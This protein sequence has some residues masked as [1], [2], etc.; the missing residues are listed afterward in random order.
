MRRLV[1]SLVVVL[2]LGA[3]A[4]NAAAEDEFDVS[5]KGRQVTVTTKGDWHINLDYPWKLVVEVAPNQPLTVPKS[6][7]ELQAKKATVAAKSGGSAVLK[8]AVC[9]QTR[10]QNGCRPFQKSLTLP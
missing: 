4:S 10:D 9:I 1:S 6:A 5:V 2:G 8:G 7:F 3:F